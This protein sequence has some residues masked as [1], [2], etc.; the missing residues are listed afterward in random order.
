MMFF[1]LKWLG[2]SVLL[3]LLIL[4]GVFTHSLRRFRYRIANQQPEGGI[5]L[6]GI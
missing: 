5:D 4:V 6:I 2:I 1:S 3:V